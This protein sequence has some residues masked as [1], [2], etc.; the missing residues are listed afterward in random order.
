MNR[1]QALQ[2]EKSRGVRARQVLDNEIYKEAMTA[3]KAELYQGFINTKFRDS[4]ERDEI[5]RK[6]QAV[7]FVESY[8]QEV[9]ETGKIAEATLAQKLKKVVGL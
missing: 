7:E 2:Q 6:Q 5:W 9:M 4:D 8:L 3:L 1:E